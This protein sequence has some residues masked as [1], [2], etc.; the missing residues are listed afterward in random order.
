MAKGQ[1]LTG[2]AQTSVP[3]EEGGYITRSTI[4][5][6]LTKSEDNVLYSCQAT[7]RDL[8]LTVA[9]SAKLMVL[10]KYKTKFYSR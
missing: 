2:D 10:C 3:S 6:K 7:N 4:A 1:Q 8:Q 5:V 9:D